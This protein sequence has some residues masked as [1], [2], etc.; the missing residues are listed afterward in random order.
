MSL[1]SRSSAV[2]LFLSLV[3]AAAAAPEAPVVFP[4]RSGDA[5]PLRDPLRPVTE[6]TREGFTLRYFT[7]E[8]CES[9][10]ELREGEIP[11]VA[12]RPAGKPS[13]REKDRVRVVEGP[14]GK[15]TLHTV[16]LDGLKPGRRYYYRI[17]DPSARPT[18]QERAWGAV[19]PWRREYAVSTL[20]AK[21][22][23]TV[24]HLPIKVLLMPNVVNVASAY[25]PN[26]GE[27]P[28]PPK[29]TKAELD[30]LREEYAVTSRFFWVNS[31]MRLWVDFQIHV[32]ERWQRW[33]PEPANVDE[34]YR[35]WPLSRSYSG[36]DFRDPGGG[37]FTFV[38]VKDP[39]RVS[40]DPVYEEHPYS[41]QVEQ[42]FPRRWDAA[43]K[44]WVYYNS[45]GGTFGVEGYPRGQHA[46]S[47]Y[48]GGGDTAWLACHEVHHELES[49][50]Q[51]S[52]G[53]REDERIIF[54]HYEPRRRVK[55]PDGKT[56]EAAWNTSG[57]H[58]E[59]WQGMAFWD[60]T[61]SDAQ[62]L[63]M[64][65]GYTIV[66]KDAD[67]DGFPDE[68]E[69]LPYDEKRFGSNPKKPA[70]DGRMSDLE[71][72]MLSTWVPSCLQYTFGKPEFQSIKP[73]PND[74]DSDRDGVTDD[75]DPYPLYPWEPHV[76][77]LRATVDGSEAEW[78]GIPLA[79][80]SAEGGI[81][82][83]FKQGYDDS[84]YYGVFNVKGPWKRLYVTL[85]GEGQGYFSG[86]GVQGFEVLNGEEV[87]VRPLRVPFNDAAAPGLK[88]KASRASE[89]RTVFEFSFPNRGE[90]M[91]F[92][93]R[94]GREIGASIDVFDEKGA[95]YSLYEPYRYFYARML[96]QV[97]RLPFP[98][99]AP[100]EITRQTATKV[101]EAR[102]PIL[103]LTGGW[104]R[105]GDVLRHTGA[106]ESALYIDGF[107]SLEFDLWARI[108]AKQDAILGAFLPDTRTLGAGEDYIAFVGGYANTVTRF[109][110]FGREESDGDVMMGPGQ[111]TIQ[112]S[113][114]GGNIWCLVNGKVVLWAVDPRPKERVDRFA[115]IGGYGGDQV[116]HELRIRL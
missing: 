28:K 41:G 79:G 47:Q 45:G 36:Q 90:G 95:G 56:E 98:P 78:A 75:V 30:R 66:V 88:W 37:E 89:G 72:V 16:T 70:T 42:A 38:D 17:H 106:G 71:K 12:W 2:L 107:N 20:A 27:V 52:L 4:K 14:G 111:H 60:R 55:R 54:N 110:L 40:A 13:G 115:V 49:H 8:A 58:G 91:W 53:Y 93:D 67:E 6:I 32:D 15:R 87:T 114:R 9:K 100:A 108:E 86:T 76:W 73:D 5:E 104:K 74:A 103:R 109:R 59:H 82:L 69:R 11:L 19:S 99:G 23:K 96:E 22:R 83:S 112:L 102:D 80:V 81:E 68:D 3:A 1:L 116:V 10:V 77:P 25:A 57:R 65:F 31:G 33:G 101:L 105:D 61:L 85:D 97:G 113:R 48:L 63:R 35:G 43:G 51:F 24:I 18:P 64:Y 46:R 34:F 44:R 21:G 94:A 62:W 84:A 26:A 92:W 29:L 39:L 7:S 50:G